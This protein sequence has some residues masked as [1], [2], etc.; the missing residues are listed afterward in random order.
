M[1]KCLFCKKEFA[2]INPKRVVC[3]SCCEQEALHPTDFGYVY[4]SDSPG[5]S[6]RA[7]SEKG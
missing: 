6:C 7:E 5:G 2:D 3:I 4:N 1:N